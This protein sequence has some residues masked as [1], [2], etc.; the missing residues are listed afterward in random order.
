LVQEKGQVQVKVQELV[1]ALELAQ[2]KVLVLA[3]EQAQ[4][5]GLVLGLVA[6]LALVFLGEPLDLKAWIGVVLMAGS[7]ALV[8][9]I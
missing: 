3:Q 4:V 8:A 6:V 9:W 7:A 2:E 1:R 5:L